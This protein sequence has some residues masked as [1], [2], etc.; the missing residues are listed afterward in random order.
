MLFPLKIKPLL[1]LGRVEKEKH[2]NELG[3][4]V[5]QLQLLHNF[6]FTC[7]NSNNHNNRNNNARVMLVQSLHKIFSENWQNLDK[8]YPK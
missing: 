6:F 4:F 1:L 5:S 8:A 3:R 7:R 2:D